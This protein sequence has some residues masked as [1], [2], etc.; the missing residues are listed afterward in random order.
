MTEELSPIVQHCNDLAA[1]DALLGRMCQTDVERLA[2]KRVLGVD[3]LD[4]VAAEA[5]TPERPPVPDMRQA[6]DHV[7]RTEETI[8]RYQVWVDS[9]P[10][11]DPTPLLE[12]QRVLRRAQLDLQRLSQEV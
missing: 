10:D 4:R 12:R 8:A 2:V 3:K 6:F 9:Y 1:V 11:D 7:A 5:F